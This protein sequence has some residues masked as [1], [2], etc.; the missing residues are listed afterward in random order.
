[1][2]PRIPPFID[3][4]AGGETPVFTTSASLWVFQAGEVLNVKQLAAL[5]GVD[6]STIK[7]SKSMSQTWF[8]RRIGVGS[9]RWKFWPS[10]DGCIG[11]TL[12]SVPPLERP[13][14]MV[15][16]LRSLFQE[17]VCQPAGLCGPCARASTH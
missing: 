7:W 1:M 6:M 10:L 5:M 8:H 14:W 11:A 15:S 16:V 2:S 17:L 9:S 3:M 12:A 4:L 13:S